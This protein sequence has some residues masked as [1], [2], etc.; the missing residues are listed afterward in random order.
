VEA[1][2][3][4]NKNQGHESIRGTTRE[5]SGSGREKEKRKGDDIKE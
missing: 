1:S 3:K 2:G 5:G 4:Q